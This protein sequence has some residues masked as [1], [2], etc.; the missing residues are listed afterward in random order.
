[1]RRARFSLGRVIPAVI[2]AALALDILM[3]LGP[4]L[5]VGEVHWPLVYRHTGEA[6]ARNVHDVQLVAGDLARLAN[7]RAF[8]LYRRL[9]FSTDAFGFR[10]LPGDGP[11]RV[12]LFGDSFAAGRGTSDD[13]TLPRHLERMLGCRVYNAAAADGQLQLPTV[14]QVLELAQRVGMRGG[15]VVV[16]RVE[17]LPF[18][19]ERLQ[20]LP[21]HSIAS[22]ALQRFRHVRD[23]RFLREPAPL[24][25]LLQDVYKRL[26][27][28]LVFPN[29]HRSQVEVAELRNGDWML[30]Y[31]AELAGY[32][33]RR[34]VSTAYWEQLNTGLSAAGFRL[35]VLLVPNKAT[36]YSGLTVPPKRV[37]VEPG[38]FLLRLQRALEAVGIP[39]VNPT[40]A[41]QA[42]ATSRLDRHGYV[43]HRDDTHWTG[44][45]AAIAAREFV[46]VAAD[47][48][49]PCAGVGRTH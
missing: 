6:W 16:E 7:L 37:P 12:I 29:V 20:S 30:L 44:D 5:T 11:I 39:V 23:S 34:E 19:K 22:N 41:L 43:Y 45:G 40:A 47:T 14:M 48:L 2:A 33:A 32:G 21:G 35:A 17:R 9:S 13:E 15:T 42:E 4:V 10:N 8:R 38:D 18:P 1:M 46:R 31:Q 49:R 27:N 26:Q 24:R 28:D 3:R 25:L 36:V